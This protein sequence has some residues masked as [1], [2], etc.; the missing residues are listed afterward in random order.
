MTNNAVRVCIILATAI[1]AFL[2]TCRAV[3]VTVHMDGN[4]QCHEN[5]TLSNCTLDAGLSAAQALIDP[6]TITIQPGNYTLHSSTSCVYH[7]RSDIQI[8]GQ[9]SPVVNCLPG[10]GCSFYECQNINVDD[11]T[12]IGCGAVHNSTSRNFTD[13][14]YSVM[15]YDV[16]IYF[17]LCFNVTI[18][19]IHISHSNGIGLVFM[20]STGFISV[21]D[22]WFTSNS[23]AKDAAGGGGV[24]IEFPDCKP[25]D[26]PCATEIR[27]GIPTRFISNGVYE[28]IRCHFVNNSAS[29]GGIELNHIINSMTSSDHY[30]FGGGGGL[31]AYFTGTAS[32]TS[33]SLNSCQ[34]KENQAVLGAGM[35]VSF[36]DVSHTND[37]SINDTNFILN[38]CYKGNILPF[39]LNTGGGVKIDVRKQSDNNRFLIYSSQFKNN[40]ATWGGGLSVYAEGTNHRNHTMNKVE[41]IKCHFESNIARTGAAIDLLCQMSS[42]SSEEIS[43]TPTIQDCTFT[44][45][46]GLYEFNDGSKGA[47]FGTVNL[48]YMPASFKGNTIFY[49]NKGSALL[50]QSS[51]ALFTE[52]ATGNFTANEGVVGAGIALMGTSWVAIDSRTQLVFEN[53]TA[54]NKGGAIYVEQGKTNY[55]AYSHTCFLRYAEQNTPPTDWKTSFKFYNN[56]PISI[57]ASSILPC[58]WSTSLNSTLDYDISQAFCNWK[59]WDF[60]DGN[61][62]NELLTLAGLLN[63][64]SNYSM[65][66]YPGWETHLT[67]TAYDDF[68][69]IVTDQT[70]FSVSFPDSTPIKVSQQY[71][72]DKG[73]TITVYGS[74]NTTA[75]LAVEAAD[76]RYIYTN[77][78][79]H[80]SPCPPGFVFNLT[81]MSCTC[82]SLSAQHVICNETEH[83]AYIRLGYCI[84]Y[85]PVGEGRYETIVSRCPFSV[86]ESKVTPVLPLPLNVSELDKQFCG[87]LKRKGKLCG[88]CQD[89]YGISIFSNTYK[90]FKCNHSY[91]NWL[92]Y[93]TVSLILPSIFFVLIIIFHIGITSAPANGFIFFSQVITLPLEVLFIDGGWRMI[94]FYHPNLKLNHGYFTNILLHPYRLWSLDF[95]SIFHYDFCFKEHLKNINGFVLHYVSAVLPLI[96]LLA[97]YTVITLHDR[98][99]RIIVH[100]WKP[101]CLLCVKLRRKW[102]GKTSIIDV[103]ATF[104]LLSYTKFVRVSIAILTPSLV[105]NISGHHIETILNYDPTIRFFHAAHAPY[106]ALAIFILA[107][108]GALPPLL[109]LLYP[110]RWFQ[111]CLSHC[112][113]QSHAL[114]AFVDT[115]QGCYKDGRNGGPDRRY[116][117][118]LYFVFRIIIF[119]I[120]TVVPSNISLLSILQIPYIVFMLMIVILQ[121]YKKGFY[122]FLDAFFFAILAI[123]SSSGMYIYTKVIITKILPE[124]VFYV[125]YA[126]CFIPFLYI[127]AYV[128]Y[129]LLLRSHWCQTHCTDPLRNR[130]KQQFEDDTLSSRLLDV[131]ASVPT[132]TISEF[133]DRLENPTRYDS[134]SNCNDSFEQSMPHWDSEQTALKR[135]V[136]VENYGTA[137]TY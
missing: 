88:E 106:A 24:Y 3:N 17:E 70:K 82:P 63:S 131:E 78:E 86:D 59:N 62:S 32:N 132:Y 75:T 1:L 66:V 29:D 134:I 47:S 109:L 116:F 124:N 73:T 36:S 103:F 126:L 87:R 84:S 100:L 6:V 71:A 91:K 108:F 35:Y 44:S 102:H 12:F 121:P 107:T 89:G 77:I 54:T 81:S 117:A 97:A 69:H 4:P 53:N 64:S 93:L 38:Q 136:N 130:F 58:V 43:L 80:I 74:P 85:S 42:Y 34:F 96:V 48:E 27:S 99:C 23:V 101:F 55:A 65:A 83:K 15:K 118:G 14:G 67:I 51:D 25:G 105:Q 33:I 112:K 95:S 120:Y 40:S 21:T 128:T 104:I 10:T 18:V 41:L 125:T 76:D 22:S 9:D 13:E 8:V 49:K 46:G 2:P 57:F 92:Y 30:A 28:F 39:S 135:N 111:R 122:N 45:N 31:L 127:V 37:V 20:A 114:Q 19:N 5:E 98:N 119:T 129:W 11:V 123:K 72:S 94:E 110:F 52:N 61:C 60:G 137:V 56:K 90:C 115:F 68:K 26:A 79:V 133:P 7:N 50:I 113:L 16:A